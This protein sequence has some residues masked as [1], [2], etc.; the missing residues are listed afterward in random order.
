MP[1]FQRIIL[2]GYLV[3]STLFLA[4]PL[5][6]HAQSLPNSTDTQTILDQSALGQPSAAIVA[7]RFAL[8]FLFI[9]VPV[10]VIL[11]IIILVVFV[12]HKKEKAS[13]A[14]HMAA[15]IHSD[16]GEYVQEQ[17][18]AGFS[19]EKIRAA[20]LEGGWDIG[21]I[22]A[23]LSKEHAQVQKN[24]PSFAQ[25]HPLAPGLGGKY[26]HSYKKIGA[27]LVGG[28]IVALILVVVLYAFSQFVGGGQILTIL[29]SFL[30]IVTVAFLIIGLPIGITFFVRRDA[31]QFETDIALARQNLAY[32][33][34]TDQE[35]VYIHDWSWAAFFGS[36]WWPLGEKIYL[37]SLFVFL[38]CFVPFGPIVLAC[39]LGREGRKMGWEKGWNSF[40]EFRARQKTMAYVV[41]LAAVILPL[42]FF[43][44]F[45]FLVS[46]QGVESL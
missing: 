36:I 30:G 20:A 44:V 27:W 28:P 1:F 5:A 26:V 46:M 22:N 12:A 29:F 11:I 35:I 3:A 7:K 24:N 37:W 14:L 21:M 32:K 25:P 31:K 10:V 23:A 42:I 2:L 19:V 41:V 15:N 13:S 17:I 16:L 9:A 8:I 40:Q 6:A 18:V 4:A 39:V 34:L 43:G 38:S 33:N 45:A